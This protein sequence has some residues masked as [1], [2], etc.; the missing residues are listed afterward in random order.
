LPCFEFSLIEYIVLFE[1]YYPEPKRDVFVSEALS[2]SHVP[3]WE[4]IPRN[5]P[6]RQFP[7]DFS[8]IRVMIYV[9]LFT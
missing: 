9:A 3:S 5:N 4:V 8:L 6:A 7:S 2:G 1:G